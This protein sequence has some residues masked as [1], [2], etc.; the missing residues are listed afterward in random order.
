MDKQYKFG[1]RG[2]LKLIKLRMLEL[3][4]D[5]KHRRRIERELHKF[6]KIGAEDEERQKE[7]FKKAV[8]NSK[9]EIK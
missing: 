1:K 9:R 2:F 6:G 7:F 8:K 5:K 3:S 4:K